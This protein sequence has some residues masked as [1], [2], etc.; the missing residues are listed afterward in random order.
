MSHNN[1]LIVTVYPRFVNKGGAQDMA[2]SIARGL[3]PHNKP[4]IMY[5]NPEINDIYT[6]Q[7]IEFVRLS[8]S[9]ISKYHKR[10]AIF[11]CHH[12]KTT[13]FLS[14]LSFLFFRKNLKIVHVSH[15]TFDTLKYLTLLPD[16]IIAVS[17]TVKEN[18]IN[19][20]KV[21]ERNVTVIYNGIEDSYN[22]L[23]RSMADKDEIKILFLGR[24]TPVK[25]QLMFVEKTEGKIDK[26]IKIF[27]AGVGAD[28]EELKLKIANS[29]QYISLGM[30][31]IKK[32]LY[33]YDYVCL[34]S[35]K[36]GLPL[37]LIEGCMYA[38]P[39]LTNNIP[40]SLEI[41][42]PGF[43]GLVGKT[44]DDIVGM[45]NSITEINVEEYQRLSNNSRTLFKTEF[46]YKVMIDKYRKYL[47]LI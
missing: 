37:S 13:T 29:D 44:W 42:H 36:E 3:Y 20:F 40:S 9:N 35:E 14:I 31:D 19:Y 15:N 22:P 6:N 8:I 23:T 47:D 18:L 45:I 38:K 41:N 43:N 5:E 16:N 1:N 25:Q 33:K 32:E 4:I 30:I 2:I 27:F 26:R 10:G 34:F 17:K 46:D 28:Y 21:P 7:D 39:L 11:L 24:I 12:R